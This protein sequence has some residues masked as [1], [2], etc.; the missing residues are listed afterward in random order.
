VKSYL[1]PQEIK[2][3]H[4]EISSLC[5]AACPMCARNNHG[6][7][8]RPNFVEN[9][10]NLED[11]DRVFNDE[12]ISLNQVLFCGTHGDPI[13]SNILIETVKRIKEKKCSIQLHTNGSLRSIAWWT[14][15]CSYLDE[16][17]RLVFGIDGIETNRLYRQ[18]TD[19]NKI[20][21]RI[22]ISTDSKAKTQWDFLVFK[23]NEHE[24]ETCKNIAKEMNVD[25]FRIRKTARF[26]YWGKF[27]VKD[28]SENIIR[29]LEQPTDSRLIH[30]DQEKMMLVKKQINQK[31]LDY[32]ISCLYQ[33]SQKIYVNSKLEVFPCCYISDDNENNSINKKLDE[34]H[35]PFN[36]LTLRSKT[37]NEILN[38]SFFKNDIVSSFSDKDKTL[39]R[40]IKTCSMNRESNQNEKVQLR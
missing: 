20:L 18:N 40:C 11:I 9:Q 26:D 33:A 15:L 37:W 36:D 31:D 29:F 25:S 28:K 6:A 16:N 39:R 8:L 10:W 38:H 21:E 22:K 1:S 23:H 24:L 34:I 27:P 17:D 14:E 2:I 30:P 4:I 32:E 12:L 13:T 7:G 5:N 3:L 35:V 19:I